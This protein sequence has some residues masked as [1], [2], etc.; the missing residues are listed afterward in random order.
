MFLLYLQLFHPVSNCPHK[1][2]ILS[3]LPNIEEVQDIYI[4]PYEDTY[5]FIEENSGSS[6]K[7]PADAQNF[8]FILKTEVFT[9]YKLFRE[10]FRHVID[11]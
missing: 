5:S 7:T 6:I 2:D 11:F 9:E 8:Y 3:N 4:K 1:Q 10:K